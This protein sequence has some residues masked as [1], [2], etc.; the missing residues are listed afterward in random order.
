MLRTLLSKRI[1]LLATT[2]RTRSIAYKAG[3]VAAFAAQVLPLFANGSAEGSS[4]MSVLID[5]K[6]AF[7]KAAEAHAHVESNANAGKVLLVVQ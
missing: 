4:R 5:S 2:L 6:F 7:A 3:L 1:Q